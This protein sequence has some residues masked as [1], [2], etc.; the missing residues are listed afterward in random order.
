MLLTKQLGF[1]GCADIVNGT[2][3]SSSGVL[4]SLLDISLPEQ[5]CYGTMSVYRLSM[6]A[7][8][9]SLMIVTDRLIVHR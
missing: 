8:V 9:R 3:S 1:R 5:F 4:T 7:A 6:S 2:N